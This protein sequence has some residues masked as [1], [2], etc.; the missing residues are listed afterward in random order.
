[1]TIDAAQLA[2]PLAA[3][4]L[5]GAINVVV[6]AGT[7]VSFPLLLLTGQAPLTATVAN[8]IGIIP[9]SLSGVAA[10]RRE[11]SSLRATVRTLLP[12][13]V[14]GGIVGAL[15]L[16]SFPARV[17]TSV[18][19]WLVAVGTLLVVLGPWVRGRVASRR[20]GAATAAG[21]P[22]HGTPEGHATAFPST[23]ALA[24]GVGGAFLLGAYGGYFSAAQGILLIGV[25]GMLSRLQIQ[26]LNAIKNL[27]V[28]AVNLIAAVVIVVH[29]PGLIDWPLA[30]LVG[31]GSSLGGLVGGRFA[32]RLSAGALRGFVVVVGVATTLVMLLR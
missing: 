20:I 7:L 16:L 1:M 2:V 25:L 10:Y 14:A 27:T 32:R 28:L 8:T 17:F 22:A 23:T 18:V 31:V 13:S 4:F 12:A 15:I 26:E 6:G 30:G 19:P 21:G 11:L 29:S 3:G 9:G 24:T 5:A